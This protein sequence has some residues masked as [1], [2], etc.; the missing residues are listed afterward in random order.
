MSEGPLVSLQKRDA[1]RARGRVVARAAKTSDETRGR[2]LFV[3]AVA[4]VLALGGAVL[5]VPAPNGLHAPGPIARPHKV[6]KL[7]CGSCHD[8]SSA[9][10][11]RLDPAATCAGCHGAH[12]STR[13]GHRTLASRGQLGC[14][15]CHPAHGEPKGVTFEESGDFV[16]WSG[17]RETRG[18]PPSRLTPGTTVPLVSSAV[19]A[20]C[21]DATNAR[22]PIA[23]CIPLRAD[24]TRGPVSFCFDEHRRAV[25]ISEAKPGVCAAQHTPSRHVAWEA[26]REAAETAPLAVQDVPQDPTWARVR[27]NAP[28]IW[29][30]SAL[31]SSIAALSVIHTARR[32]KRKRAGKPDAAAP[33]VPAER[34]RLPQIDT[35]TCLGCYACV[36]A[37]PFDVLEVQRYVAVVVR[38]DDCCG[39]SLCQQVCP[40]DSLRITEGE[41]I[42]ERPRVDAH[43]ESKDAPGVFLAGDLTGLPLIKNAIR[44]GARVVERIAAT[45][46]KAARASGT[47]LDLVIVGAGPAGISAALK[48]KERGLR[49]VVLEQASVAASI[50]SF[51]RNKLVFDQ[52][53]DVPIEGELWL[54]ESTKEELLAQWTRIVR[55]ERLD[56]R[57]RH[58]VISITR[59]T[60]G[61]L[62]IQAE[63]PE[64]SFTARASRLVLAIGRRGSPRPLGAEIAPGAE[65]KVSYALADARSFAG[66]KVLVVGLGDAAMEA[67]AAIARQPGAEVAISYRGDTFARGKARNI[68]ELRA[69]EAKGRLR[70]VWSSKV[71][72]VERGSA[73][74][75]APS[76]PLAIANDAVLVLIG[77]VPSWALVREAGV[78][79]EVH[80]P[81]PAAA[82]EE[83]GEQIAEILSN[84]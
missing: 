40:N 81:L 55:K 37:C 73:R 80:A 75:V 12:P 41:P 27:A 5:V 34:V 33:L 18:T 48:A 6:A 59:E 78:Q 63:A 54:R 22:D 60:G 10:G 71:E 26:A 8:R 2:D 19:C 4:G 83:R 15:S 1:P 64:G 50:K 52:P 49:Y 24:G 23:S 9:D 14:A 13:A 38:P 11:A 51:P 76:G 53:L 42:E 7:E 29:I 3:A 70:I 67:A 46:P 82:A 32:L 31:L 36:D 62:I 57:E 74:L 72:L 69:L 25:G 21:H 44:Q 16:L 39:V 65:D 43:L 58:R 20:R 45:L 17:V 47:D 77:G 28:W 68:A 84:G 56:I 79:L 61:S 66:Q 30:A 35:R